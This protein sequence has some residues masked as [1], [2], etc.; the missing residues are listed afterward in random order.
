MQ[1]YL[2]EF[3]VHVQRT[4]ADWALAYIVAYGGIDGEHHKTW[5][6]DQ[7]TRILNGTPVLTVMAKWSNESGQVVQEV[8]R[9]TTGQPSQQYLDFVTRA[10]HGEDGPN[11]YEWDQGISP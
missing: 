11:T 7:V 8:L 1:N 4:P 10:N 5:V 9:F 3:P 2:G 6:L